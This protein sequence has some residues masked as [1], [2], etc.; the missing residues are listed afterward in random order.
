MRPLWWR[1]LFAASFLEVT[2]A[3]RPS[4]ATAGPIE[5]GE[6]RLQC[7]DY[8][9]WAYRR[10][11]PFSTG[12][13]ELAHQRLQPACRTFNLSEVEETIAGMKRNIQDPD[14][15][16][17]FENSFPNTLDTAIAW[18]GKAEKIHYFGGHD[19][20]ELTFITTGDINAMWLRDSANQ[21][22]SYKS[23]LKP[24]KSSSSLASLFR[25]YVTPR[26]NQTSVFECKYELDS[27]AAFL[28]LSHDYFV[29]TSDS[30]FFGRH[31]WV[32]AIDT[33]MNVT[34]ELLAGT[35]NE[36]GT[37]AI[38]PYQFQR[39]TLTSTETLG[40]AGVGSPVKS[41]TGLIR[42]AFRPSDDA[43]TYQLFVPANMMFSR[44]LGLCVRI[45]EKLDEKA[46]AKKIAEFAESIRVG[47]ERYGRVDH[48]VYGRIYAYEVDGF[49][50]HNVM[51]DANIPSL[52]S[53][54]MFG[55]LGR[56]DPIYLNTR[57]FVLSK[58][59]PYFMYGP[60]MN[61]T[62]GPHIGP[63][64]AWPMGLIAQIMTTDDD[65][66]IVSAL[67]Q[68][69]SSTDGLGLI[70]ESVNTHSSSIWTRQWYIP[71]RACLACPASG[72]T[73]PAN[74]LLV[75]PRFSWA[76]GL[77]GQMMLDLRERKPHL[78]ARSYQ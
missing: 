54:P 5:L 77:F 14:L 48:P 73:C 16:R 19:E 37:V 66:E 25:D 50:S 57:R 53:A 46:K 23:L 63:G 1:W 12:K 67:K 33:I 44:Y 35:Y 76:N 69:L 11:P 17:L 65:A 7:P 29:G 18:H 27:L 51:D 26:P 4:K 70:H 20:E 71:L 2:S 47:I 62:G 56:N 32:Q 9:W 21:L 58:H 45:M 13:Y 72:K 36:N 30:A 22:H 55:Y 39:T 74:H 31:R 8:S 43:C 15:F 64:M 60:V 52:L 41:G 10:N 59:N 40:S 42:S 24:N 68:L 75:T 78:L 38:S 49:G 28:Q 61:A 3:R 6:P 34:T